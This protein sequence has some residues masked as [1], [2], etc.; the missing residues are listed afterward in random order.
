MEL[1]GAGFGCA[2]GRG[3]AAAR[4]RRCRRPGAPPPEETQEGSPRGPAIDPHI[5]TLPPLRRERF[6]P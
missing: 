5:P 1:G 3:R 4:Q 2:K 6:F